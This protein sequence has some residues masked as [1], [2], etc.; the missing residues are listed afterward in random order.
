[1]T[2]LLITN[3]KSADKSQIAR[4]IAAANSDPA[5]HCLHCDQE[6]KGIL[7]ELAMLEVLMEESFLVA[8]DG[9]QM[10]G[11]LGADL[12]LERDRAW[13]WGPFVVGAD[14]KETAAALYNHFINHSQPQIRQL[15]QFLNAANE[16]GRAF[17][18]SQGFKELKTSHV[19]RALPPAPS[20]T[21]PY[22]EITPPQWR[23][24]IALHEETF[25]TTYYSGR[26]II[27]RLGKRDKVFVH[28]DGETV[29]GYIYA[30]VEP[31]EGFIHFLAVREEMRRQ[32]IG[33]RLLMTAASWLFHKQKVPQIGLVVDD[34]NNARRLYE[35]SGFSLL[36][37]GVGLRKEM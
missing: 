7:N 3:A 24:F 18:L 12:T 31:T 22:S 2:H 9:E 34:Q 30:N 36:Y 35:R 5:H 17:Y 10:V 29:S 14:W 21:E 1:M 11:V 33:E 32:G 28:A 8:W 16:Q 4:L 19:Y 20:I 27:E 23:S 13:L 15:N 37:S 26:E 25:P 6:E